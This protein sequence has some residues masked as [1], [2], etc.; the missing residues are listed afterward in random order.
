MTGLELHWKG[1][2]LPHDTATCATTPEARGVAIHKV[3]SVV[4][5][6]FWIWFCLHGSLKLQKICGSSES[7]F[8]QRNTFQFQR[9]L[10][11]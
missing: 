10:E 9:R 5:S 7:H 1:V 4:S 2:T 6:A 11:T 3:Q 8:L